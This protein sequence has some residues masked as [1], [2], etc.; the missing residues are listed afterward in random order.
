[1]LRDKSFYFKADNACFAANLLF[2]PVMRFS[3][4]RFAF[5]I[6][7]FCAVLMPQERDP[8]IIKHAD[9]FEYFNR[10]GMKLQKLIG[11]VEI[12]Y[13]RARIKADTAIHSPVE[14]R[15][16]F[17]KNVHL[18][19]DSQE[20][21]ADKL[22]YFKKDSSAIAKGHVILSDARQ[23]S[24]IT[25]GEGRYVR[26]TQISRIWDN[27]ILLRVDSAA[28]DSLKIVS[29]V[30]E[31]Y[32]KEKK[33]VAMD[34]VVLTQGRMRAY[35]GRAEYLQS[36]ETAHLLNNPVVY[37]DSS[38]LK[39]DTIRLFFNK[40]TL[41]KIRVVGNAYGNL[42]EKR[43]G[44][45]DSTQISRIQGD[46]LIAYLKA[47]Q[48][49]WMEVLEHANGVNYLKSDTARPNTLSGKSMR[50]F[51]TNNVIDSVHVFNN[52]KS[53]Y[54]YTEA[55]QEKG[56]NEMSGDTLNIF[57]EDNRVS[58]ILARGSIRGTFYER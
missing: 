11:R 35:C 27:P 39:G 54:Y 25:G 17:F 33:A 52:A 2:F 57:F 12:H 19:A 46:T 53:I 58:H 56:K 5:F 48:I 51:F 44:D 41:R 50:F 40:D 24:R 45:P 13:Q 47:K 29:Q 3:V 7:V 8:L 18:Y 43:Q 36:D 23:K 4:A 37:Y 10:N 6:F 26:Q 32:G 21:E 14:E 42:L 30:M 55:T 15:I 9:S 38:E 28:G 1:M 49:D 16:D 34:K 22:T 31:H 20:L